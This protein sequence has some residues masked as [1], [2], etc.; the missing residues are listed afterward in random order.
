VVPNAATRRWC[1]ADGK[2]NTL[3]A[4]LNA[5][6]RPLSVLGYFDAGALMRLQSP[7]RPFFTPLALTAGT[8]DSWVDRAAL[9]AGETVLRIGELI[10][11]ERAVNELRPR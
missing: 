11:A 6:S 8:P 5:A 10:S 7:A 1:G 2:A 3:P 9:Y 4:T